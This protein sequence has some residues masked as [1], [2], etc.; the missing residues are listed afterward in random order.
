MLGTCNLL[1][2]YLGTF[3]YTQVQG[4]LD[5]PRYNG[6]WTYLG[7]R[8]WID[9]GTRDLGYTQVHWTLDVVWYKGSW[10]LDVPWYKGLDISR[11]ERFGHPQVQSILN[12]FSDKVNNK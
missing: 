1:H 3:G 5:I 7:T 2:R 4:I 10:I 6:Y 11:Y 12:T 9:L 8:A